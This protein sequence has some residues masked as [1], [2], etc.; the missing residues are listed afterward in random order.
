MITTIMNNRESDNLQL[1]LL[2]NTLTSITNIPNLID[3]HVKRNF[4]F[5][6]F[7]TL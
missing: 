1:N 2:L 3:E 7:Q 5:L 4:D 6:N